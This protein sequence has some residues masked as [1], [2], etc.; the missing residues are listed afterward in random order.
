[1]ASD[2]SLQWGLGFLAEEGY[3][4]ELRKAGGTTLQWGLGFLAEKDLGRCVTLVEENG[5]Q[6][7]L[8]FLAEEGHRLL[9]VE[10]GGGQ[11]FNGASA[12]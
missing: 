1:M 6:W 10:P 4:E 12:F 5:L 11:G 8:G 9:C 7:G 2:K 3:E